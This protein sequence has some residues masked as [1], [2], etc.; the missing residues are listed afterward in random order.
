MGV[1]SVGSTTRQGRIERLAASHQGSVPWKLADTALLIKEDILFMQ[2]E[3]FLM[4]KI[5]MSPNSRNTPRSQMQRWVAL[6]LPLVLPTGMISAFFPNEAIAEDAVPISHGSIVN[7]SMAAYSLDR[8]IDFVKGQEGSQKV[9]NQLIQSGKG[10][11]TRDVLRRSYSLEQ[12]T[13]SKKKVDSRASLLNGKA[14]ETFALAM[15]DSH[16][17][18]S[19]VDWLPVSAAAYRLSGDGAIKTWIV[20]QLSEISSWDKLQ[21]PGWTLTTPVG[22]RLPESGDGSWLA[23]GWG[24]R[25]IAD[26]LEILPENDVPSDIKSKIDDLLIREI[27]EITADW[28]LKRQWFVKNGAVT[29]NQWVL[30]T[31][32]L[33][34]ACIV[35]GKDRFREAYELGVSNILKTLDAS[36]SKGEWDEGLTY[37]TMTLPEILHTARA[38]ASIGDDRL[39]NHPYLQNL[40]TWLAH[41]L[42]PG[43]YL[44]NAFDSSYNSSSPGLVGTGL[45]RELFSLLVLSQGDGVARWTLWHQLGGPRPTLAGIG[46]MLVGPTDVPPA[47]WGIYERATRVNWRSSWEDDASGIWIRGG[48]ERDFHDHTD[49]G[50]VSFSISGKPILIE[51]GTPD[52]GHAELDRY[53]KSVRGHSVL[54]VE[55][56]DALRKPAPITVRS[57]GKDGGALRVDASLGYPSLER[58]TR[59]VEFGETRLLVRDEVIVKNGKYENL[60]FRWHL[61]TPARVALTGGKRDFVA[62]WDNTVITIRASAE[63]KLDQYDAEDRTLNRPEHKGNH[64]VLEV[65]SKTPIS[66][67]TITTE[68]RKA[69]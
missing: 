48:H 12:L 14:K 37:A 68:F 69:F 54:E 7:G 25:A 62:S 56:K 15:S 6:V 51:A 34:R 45:L 63:V 47:T 2:L 38:M 19:L 20:N 49:R 1:L 61:G 44:I 46:A 59:D 58:W 30:P 31:T 29:S 32:G 24:V 53:F 16:L 41:H 67:L 33:I 64:V 10:V 66:Q 18:G 22:T 52:Y 3:S 9:I 36:G 39:I 27:K 43:K 50:H 5:R 55:S 8:Q 40:S 26:T 60:I 21:R 13:G 11:A 35:V 23:T 4:E 42:Q 28:E 65:R 17:T 57:L